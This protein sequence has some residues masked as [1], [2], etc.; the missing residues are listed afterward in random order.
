MER[1]HSTRIHS[2][3][4]SFICLLV[5]SSLCSVS[6]SDK[7]PRGNWAPKAYAALNALIE[8]YGK[9]SAGYDA[10]NKPYA[11]FDFDNT[12]AINDVEETL[13][14]FQLNNLR[15]K[16]RP[17]EMYDVLTSGISDLNKPL[18]DFNGSLKDHTVTLAMMAKDITAD[19]TYLYNHYK[20]LKGTQSLTAIQKTAQFL[21]FRAKVRFLYFSVYNTYDPTTGY[22]WPLYLFKGMTTAE[23]QQLTKNSVDYWLKQPFGQQK[24]ESPA[25][26]EAGKV[27]A[28]VKTGFIISPEMKDLYHTL[29]SNGIDVYICS[30]SLQEVVAAIA[31]DAKYGLGL[32]NDHVFAMM[33]RKEAKT[34]R[35]LAQNDDRYPMTCAEGKVTAIKKYIASCHHGQEPI[36]VG[37]DSDGDYNML[38]EFEDMKCGLIFNRQSKEKIGGL[39]L[40]A[41]NEPNS[42]Y[43]LQGRNDKKGILISSEN[44]IL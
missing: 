6:A 16:I 31:T 27:W 12:T 38:T 32:N 44:S 10:N 23:L 13:L 43:I 19:Y 11:V 14:A 42:K 21:D 40:K 30:A 33:L 36:L 41:Q 4:Y 2:F 3:V 1:L 15:F 5:V 26:G 34:K 28:P 35:F 37:G 18:N 7:L 20:G 9:Q 39:Y 22:F 17:N 8:Q 24:W 25:M 29:R